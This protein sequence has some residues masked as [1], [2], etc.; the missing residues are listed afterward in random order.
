MSTGNRVDLGQPGEV[1]PLLADK[2]RHKVGPYL[3]SHGAAT[4]HLLLIGFDLIGKLR[5]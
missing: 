4:A 5:I 1:D 2:S 3:P